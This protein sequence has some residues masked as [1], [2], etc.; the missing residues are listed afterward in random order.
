MRFSAATHVGLVRQ[1]NEDGYCAWE[2]AGGRLGFFAVADGLG[3]HTAGE[4]A[5]R[6]A[7]ETASAYARRA[8]RALGWL[9]AAGRDGSPP[10]AERGPES[11][12]GML[13]RLMSFANGRVFRRARRE[14]DLSGMGT[15]LTALLVASPWLA[16]AHVGDSRAYLL[17][18]G[19]V[20]RLTSD[21]S[22]VEEMVRTGELSE[23]EA[24]SHPQRHVLT[25]ALGVEPRVEPDLL[26]QPLRGG[27][28]VVLATDGVTALLG[29]EEIA[30]AVLAARQDGVPPA[31]RL[32]GLA[33]A[34]G[35]YDNATCVV[36]E[37]T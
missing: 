28:I 11:L 27:D 18:G 24:R 8:L 10:E 13:V 30:G 23:G 22:L 4:V 29:P 17:R 19:Q 34:R 12:E 26:V 25:R 16:L 3:G 7:L 20:V 1:R 15:T 2:E 21:H 5:S 36:V 6:L 9:P 37:L 35:G 32:V 14:P 33:N 31:D